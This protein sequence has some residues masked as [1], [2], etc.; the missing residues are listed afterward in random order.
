MTQGQV[1]QIVHVLKR[2]AKSVKTSLEHDGL[3]DKR[4][5]MTQVEGDHSDWIAIPIIALPDTTSAMILSH[6]RQFC[7]Y[8]TSKLGNNKNQISSDHH[9]TLVQHALL[10]FL[11]G[12]MTQNT[13]DTQH[14]IHSIQGL[15]NRVCPRTLEVIGDDR[16]LVIPR[17]ALDSNHEPLAHLIQNSNTSLHTQCLWEI[18]AQV[19]HSP[20]VV[21]RG[22]IDPQ[23][24]IRESGHTILWPI[25]HSSETTT[26]TTTTI[27]GPSSPGWITITEQ[28]ISQSF[29]LTKVMFSRGNVTEKIRF[30]TL[31]QPNEVVLDMYAGIGYYTLPALIK[32]SAKHVYACEWNPH[33]ALAL[34][35]N[36]KANQVQDRAT[37]YIGDSRTL[38]RDN[39]ISNMV[40]RIS[41]G[42]LPSSE[43]GWRT[44]LTALRHDTGGW[45]HVHANVPV[46][47]RLEWTWWLCQSLWRLTVER[48]D[49]KW[50]VYCKHVEKVK[51]FAPT[52]NH[53]VADIFCGPRHQGKVTLGKEMI[54]VCRSDGQLEQMP[55]SIGP[56]SCAL[57]PNGILN[58]AW[59][60]EEISLG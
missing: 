9:L 20:R 5:R 16:T 18:L 35:Y 10:L 59:M 27:I 3:L 12:G 31:V 42:L 17:Y 6:G 50:I 4:F 25:Y 14:W 21:R 54:G 22:E 1:T 26:T 32:G 47:E 28:G 45:L 24:A 23:S 37:V 36:L 55:E 8:S 2:H 19:Y 33:A 43:G 15:D 7:L 46:L 57:D 41:L 60:R 56:P 48:G 39:N 11:N 58:Q 30:G 40:D 13:S 51:S 49:E 38:C 44:A 29:D 34:Q 53:Y 52:I